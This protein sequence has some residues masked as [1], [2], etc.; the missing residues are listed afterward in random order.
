MADD[1]VPFLNSV[2]AEDTMLAAGATD[3]AAI[4]V[5]SNEDHGG[6]VNPAVT[7]AYI[8]FIQYQSIGYVDPESTIELDQDIKFRITPN[9]ANSQ[10]SISFDN[11]LPNFERIEILSLEGKLVQS[12]AEQLTFSVNDLSSGM[13]IV[14]VIS[15]KGVWLEK[16]ILDR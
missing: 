13:Y 4:D 12:S 11:E 2:I 8:F 9:P 5:N 14:K 6:C 10:I 15:D 3:L 7:S 16:L 1:Q